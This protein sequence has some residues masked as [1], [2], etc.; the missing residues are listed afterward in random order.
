MA[1]LHPTHTR[2]PTHPV[3][4]L[5]YDPRLRPSLRP[6]LRPS[7]RPLSDLLLPTSTH[8]HPL[9]LTATHWYSMPPT[10]THC[11][12]LLLAATHCYSLVTT[13]V[14]TLA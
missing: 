6:L 3:T 4:T 9:L 11:Y 8:C 14:T 2:T 10:A 13:P 7:L 12:P 1:P 5:G